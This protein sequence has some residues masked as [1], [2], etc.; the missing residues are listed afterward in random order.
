MLARTVRIPKEVLQLPGPVH[1]VPLPGEEAGGARKTI[2]DGL[3]ER[4]P[5]E[6]VFGRWRSS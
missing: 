6:V 3:F 5:T 2:D 4:C 1:F